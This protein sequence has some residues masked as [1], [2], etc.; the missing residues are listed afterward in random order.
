MIAPPA[1]TNARVQQLMRTLAALQQVTARVIPPRAG[2]KFKMNSNE[3][4]DLG[5]VFFL[6][7]RRSRGYASANSYWTSLWPPESYPSRRGI[8]AMISSRTAAS[9]RGSI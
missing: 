1:H 7:P 6:R 3:Q 5:S 8:G 9:L 4:L 2:H